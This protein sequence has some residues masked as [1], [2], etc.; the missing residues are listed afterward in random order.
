MAQRESDLNVAIVR[1][2]LAL[3]WVALLLM[4]GCA[5]NAHYTVNTPLER[6]PGAA[7]YYPSNLTAGDNSQSLTI[8]LALSGGGTRAAA[9]AYGVL[10]ALARQSITW[11]GQTKRLLDEVDYITS[12]SGGSVTAA[13]YALFRERLFTDFEQRFLRRDA[14]SDI[15]N[16]ITAFSNF[17]RLQSPRFSRIDLVQEYLDEVLFEGKTFADMRAVNK[18]PMVYITATDMTLG[19]R[20]EFTQ[21]TF[22]TLCSDLSTFPVSR[23]VAASMAVPVLFSPVTVWSYAG[24]C[25]AQG[26]ALIGPPLPP[27]LAADN[28]KVPYWQR[29][30]KYIHLLDGGLADNVGVRGALDHIAQSGG[31]VRTMKRAG[32]RGIKK[33]VFIIVNAEA[34]PEFPEDNSPDAPTTARTLR[35][36]VD[37]PIN[38]YT[39]GSLQDLSEQVEQWKREIRTARPEELGGAVDRNAEFYIISIDFNGS[40]NPEER[41]KL[42]AIPTTLSLSAEQIETLKA[43][44][45]RELNESPDY[46]RLIRAL[47]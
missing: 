16:R 38:R 3:V 30:R 1:T 26:T 47:K 4:A 13:Y 45:E 20:F 2:R 19:N 22:D 29:P 42:R 15:I 8:N 44:A 5:T 40:K 34:I 33:F 27:E 21:Q 25:P 41:I 17:G 36:L 7:G 35:A 37:I 46:Q 6:K 32:A 24:D 39:V 18:R 12:V 31:I 10:Q 11:E 14:Q 28:E 23:A 9:L 43:F